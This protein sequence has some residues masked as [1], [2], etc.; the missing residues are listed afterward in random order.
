[1]L[2]VSGPVF[3]PSDPGPIVRVAVFPEPFNVF[4]PSHTRKITMMITEIA[5][6]T[7]KKGRNVIGLSLITGN[8]YAHSW[9]VTPQI[10]AF[11]TV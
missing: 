4:H 5:R 3:K 7:A 8:D 9:C 10:A 11:F 1:V 2:K 6:P